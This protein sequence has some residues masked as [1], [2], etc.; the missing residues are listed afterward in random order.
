MVI[1]PLNWSLHSE[2]D[3]AEE[4][5]RKRVVNKGKMSGGFGELEEEEYMFEDIL[6]CCV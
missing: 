3:W 2:E 5:K 1:I 4:R 6:F